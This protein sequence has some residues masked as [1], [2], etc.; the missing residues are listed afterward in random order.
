MHEAPPFFSSIHFLRS[1][2][3]HKVK[4]LKLSISSKSSSNSC[5]W[6]VQ[7]NLFLYP[8]EPP[9]TFHCVKQTLYTKKNE[10]KTHSPLQKSSQNLILP[11]FSNGCPCLRPLQ[12][13]N[14][15][16]G[17]PLIIIQNKM[18]VRQP[19]IQNIEHQHLHCYLQPHIA[20]KWYL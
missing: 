13:Q 20:R 4:F 6:D 12:P 10:S 11:P 5:H 18:E 3:R 17:L 9:R 15:P 14:F 2:M 7:K 8:P 16:L 19:W 1:S